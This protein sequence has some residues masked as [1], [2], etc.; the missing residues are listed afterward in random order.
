MIPTLVKNSKFFVYL[1]V[2]FFVNN[3]IM[4]GEPTHTASEMPSPYCLKSELSITLRCQLYST[5]SRAGAP[6]DFEWSGHPWTAMKVIIMH[7][8]QFLLI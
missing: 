8:T 5:H 4:T 2:N 7:T 1:F 6:R 3:F